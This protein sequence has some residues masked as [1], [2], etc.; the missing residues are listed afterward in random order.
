[1]I[2]KYSRILGNLYISDKS[3][4]GT[5]MFIAIGLA[6]YSIRRIK[7]IRAVGS[8]KSDDALKVVY[9]RVKSFNSDPNQERRDLPSNAWMEGGQ[10]IRN[11]KINILEDNDD[12]DED[13]MVLRQQDITDN[14]I[15]EEEKDK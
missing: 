14:M 2:I 3:H 1:M 7:I 11:S 9:K 13:E 10:E 12:G 15:S 8:L 5:L 4:L 6:M